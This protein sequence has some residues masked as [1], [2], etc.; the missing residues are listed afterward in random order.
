MAE[1]L[2]SSQIDI[3]IKWPNDILVNGKKIAG[4]L[5]E[6]TIHNNQISWCVAGIGINVN[7]ELIEGNPN[8]TS[9]KAITGANY[10]VN[11]ILQIL[12]Q[13][14]EKHYL[15]LLNSR[16]DLISAAYL[17]NLFGL[18]EF[19]DFEWKGKIERFCV[20]GVGESGLLLL[21]NETE[22][23]MQMDVKDIKWIY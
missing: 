12:C 10:S 5:I 8:A 20:K 22:Q 7:Q 21:Q 2:D 1:I 16:R 4:I 3:K 17:K 23:H 14:L 13:Q 9:L 11:Y 18:N 6:N 15:S 19:R